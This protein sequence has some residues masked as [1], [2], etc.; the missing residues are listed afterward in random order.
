MNRLTESLNRREFLKATMAG[1]GGLT[2]SALG[3]RLRATEALGAALAGGTP[4]TGETP[5]PGARVFEIHEP[6]LLDE[7]GNVRA[8]DYLPGVVHRLLREMTGS[9]RTR[10]AWHKLF[11]D[12]DVIGIQFD[13]IAAKE[14][15]T[16]AP[17]ARMLIES[18]LEAGFARQKIML[19][20]GPLYTAEFDT[21]PPPFGYEEQAVS[22]A[23]KRQT[24]F[25]RALAEVTAIL[26]VPFIKDHR[27]LGLSCGT[28]NLALGLINNP[29]AFTDPG[30][31][32]GVVDLFA[33]QA[34]R[35]KHRLTLVNGI[36][37]IYDRGPRAIEGR[38]WNQHAVLGSTDCIALDRVALDLVNAAR[39]SRGLKGLAEVGRDPEY[40]AAAARRGLGVANLSKIQVRRV[41]I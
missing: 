10:D 39:F 38:M 26:N 13:P 8:L 28:V 41:S 5:S 6:R 12:K 35:S 9:R 33:H 1:L 18:L 22:V 36:R 32:P 4:G 2:L 14:L 3:G 11:S 15:R 21:R 16:S 20:H 40:L 34:I 23:K 7:F 37:G 30:G 27:S 17:M 29:G 25:L 24:H 19:I 31:D